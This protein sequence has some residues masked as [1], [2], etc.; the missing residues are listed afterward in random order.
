MT[1]GGLPI[2]I[3]NPQGS[4]RSGVSKSGKAWSVE[5]GSHYGYLK[6]TIGKDK[7][8]IDVF[9]KPGTP[10]SYDGPVYVVDQ[11]DPS[12]DRFDEHKTV[13][14]AGSLNE[15]KRIYQE[16]Y[17]KGWKGLQSITR[18]SMPEFKAWLKSGDTKKPAANYTPTQQIVKSDNSETLPAVGVPP[19]RTPATFPVPPKGAKTSASTSSQN[20]PQTIKTRTGPGMPKQEPW[21]MTRA[22]FVAHKR[23]ELAARAI[24]NPSLTSRAH[25][26]EFGRR[27]E[28]AHA[29][30]VEQAMADGKAVPSEVLADYPEAQGIVKTDRSVSREAKT[31]RKKASTRSKSQNEQ[32]SPIRELSE[33]PSAPEPSGYRRSRGIPAEADPP[34]SSYRNNE[35]VK[36]H[37]DYRA[38]KAGDAKAAI[39]VVQDLVKP[40]TLADAKRRFAGSIFVAPLAQ[41]ASGLNAIPKALAAH[42]A[43]AAGGQTDSRITQTNKVFH[44]G[45][46]AMQRL[47]ARPQFTGAVTRGARYVLIDDVTTMGGTFAELAHHIR[48]GGGEVVGVVALTNAARNENLTPS[49]A[50]IRLLEERFGDAIRETFGVEPSALTAPE[51]G[52]LSNFRDADDLRARAARAEE[53]RNR[54]LLT[55]GVSQRT[56]PDVADQA[57][58]APESSIPPSSP[59]EFGA[60]Q[61][62]AQESDVTVPSPRRAQRLSLKHLTDLERQGQEVADAFLAAVDHAASKPRPTRPRIPVAPILGGSPKTIA[63]IVIDVQK[64]TGKKV[65]TGKAGRGLAGVYKPGSATTLVRYSGDLDTTAHELAHA[66]DDEYGIV[67]SYTGQP[68]SPFDAELKPFGEHGSVQTTGP[69]ST[70][71]YWRAE[72]VAEW[73]RAWLVNP[74]AAEAAAPTFTQHFKRVVPAHIQTAL[75]AFS[76]DIRRHA[77]QSAHAKIMANVEWETPK[78]PLLAWLTGTRTAPGPGFQL[79]IGDQLATE[80]TDRLTPFMKAVRYAQG[81]R[82]AERPLPGKDPSLLARL[83]MGMNAKLDDVFEHGMIDAQLQRATPGGLTWLLGPLDPQALEA[84]IQEVASLMIAQRTMEKAR[85]LERDRVSGIGAGIESDVSVARARLAELKKDAI[86]YARLQDAASRYRQWADA[87]L[88]YLVDK[89]RLSAEQ[90]AAIKENNEFYVAMQ[91]IIEVSPGEELVVSLPRGTAGKKLGTVGQPVKTFS[92]STRTIK[93][94]YHALMDAT[95]QAI[96]EADR[97]EV[98]SLFRDLLTMDRGMHEGQVADLAS[99]GRLAATGEKHTIPIYKNGEKEIWQFH[100]EVYAALKGVEEGAYTFPWVLTILP[101]ILRATIVNA[102]P[103]ALRNLIRDAWQ[104]TIVSRVGSKPWDVLKP[105]SPEEITKFQRSGG[106]QAGHYYTSPQEY[107]RALQFAMRELSGKNGSILV[108]PA[109]LGRGYLNLMQGSERQGRMAEYRRAFQ[110]AK[111]EFGYDDYHAS[112]WAAGQ[113]RDLLDF[114]VAGNWT[115]L[116]NQLVPF[117]NAAVQGLRRNIKGARENPAGVALRF[118]IYALIPSLVNFAWNYLF[119]DGDDLDEYRELPA[120]Q[121]DLFYNYKLGPDQ[122]LSIPKAFEVGV[123][124]TTFERAMDYGLGNEKAFDGHV[125]AFLR[126]LLPIDEAAFGGPFQGIFQA[127]ANYDFFRDRPIVPRYEENLALDLRNTHRASRLGQAIQSAIGVDARKIDFVVEQQFGYF[128]RYATKASDIGREEKRGFGLD[129]VGLFRGSPATAALDVQKIKEIATERGLVASRGKNVDRYQTVSAVPAR[130]TEHVKNPDAVRFGVFRK[131]LD[132][133]YEAKGPEAKD[134]AAKILRREAAALRAI[135]EKTPPKQGAEEKVEIT[136]K[137]DTGEMSKDEATKAFKEMMKPKRTYAPFPIEPA[138]VP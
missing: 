131:L 27:A 97:N 110:H 14:G 70:A 8:Q 33:S 136:R 57:G 48:Q 103:F 62:D 52:Y 80:L 41:E 111:K 1:I 61:R 133:Y 87:N 109:R 18:F 72:G 5:M 19:A 119:G 46:D 40:E 89:G 123:L 120:Y 58:S 86:K 16:N 76:D 69:R 112:L 124:A 101:R 128:G 134:A 7:D 107:G 81:Q 125:G 79:T 24:Q 12:T 26:A 85:Q 88:R 100:P 53:H 126:T 21:Q 50:R 82:N 71:T 31:T 115:Q 17:A 36:A 90:Y 74:Q 34:I 94:P 13:I 138:L 38:A 106:D 32:G 78:S 15:A 60:P 10:E 22:E 92:G 93:N 67:K 37:P 9:V 51:A 118:G 135:W 56:D 29:G 3:E 129:T 63:N 54:R 59:T 132:A 73:T 83:Y 30:I 68:S 11:K 49:P 122:W 130:P 116:V 44:T 102:P 77:G 45:A 121:R 75:Q 47:I 6:G 65:T 20:S 55:K 84:E 2:S 43:N 137:R 23:A 114:A 64:G 39:R 104:R 99:V 42:Y 108:D 28:I 66:L 98:L 95:N 105:Y 4:T 117:T 113:A 91:R 127:V 25:S 96:R 35:T